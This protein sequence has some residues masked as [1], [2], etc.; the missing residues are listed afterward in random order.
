MGKHVAKCIIADLGQKKRPTFAYFDKGQ[1]ATIGRRRAI[2]QSGPIKLAGTL[3]W[4]AW[5]FIHLMV[6]VTYR[7]RLLVFMKWSWAWFSYERASRLIW[8]PDTD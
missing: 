8:Q 3:A 5:L 2:M 6:L 7:N 1:M 4:L